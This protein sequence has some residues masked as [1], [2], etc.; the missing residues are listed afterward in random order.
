MIPFIQPLIEGDE[1]ADIETQGHVFGEEAFHTH[2]VAGAKGVF[3]G[4]D[5]G[6][7][8]HVS[9]ADGNIGHELVAGSEVVQGFEA[10]K[11]SVN[12][13]GG[14]VDIGAI[15][16]V[17]QRLNAKIFGQV[18]TEPQPERGV[19]VVFKVLVAFV[20]VQAVV[21][22]KVGRAGPIAGHCIARHEH[23]W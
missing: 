14:A 23:A 13:V 6:V 20:L 16:D 19:G 8:N 18:V 15:D 5:F 4:S 10:V 17:G 2:A 3:A 21:E 11:R 1:V 12:L 9:G 7:Q 22:R